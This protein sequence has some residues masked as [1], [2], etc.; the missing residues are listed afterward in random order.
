MRI[1]DSLTDDTLWADARDFP[2]YIA[3][4]AMAILGFVLELVEYAR[5]SPA[6]DQGP[7][8]HREPRLAPVREGGVNGNSKTDDRGVPE[9]KK[10]RK[11]EEKHEEDDLQER[12][13]DYEGEGTDPGRRERHERP[14]QQ[15]RRGE[16]RIDQDEVT[17]ISTEPKAENDGSH[18][19]LQDH[20]QERI[21]PEQP[22]S[23][24][25]S[26]EH[27]KASELPTDSPN[28]YE[29]PLFPRTEQ[30]IMYGV[31]SG[32][33]PLRMREILVGREPFDPYN[34]P[35]CEWLPTWPLTIFDSF[36]TVS[37]E[38][39]EIKMQ[40]Q[41]DMLTGSFLTNALITIV[42]GHLLK[43]YNRHRDRSRKRQE[44][45]MVY[46]EANGGSAEMPKA[47]P[48]LVIEGVNPRRY[49][50]DDMFEVQR[51]GEPTLVKLF[52]SKIAPIEEIVP[53][54]HAT[55]DSAMRKGIK[56]QP[57]PTHKK[58]GKQGS[59]LVGNTCKFSL[60][61]DDEE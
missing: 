43:Y 48:W 58:R 28:Q 40:D 30:A 4:V 15:V 7:E 34:D 56:N 36:P 13:K 5:S 31:T 6:P 45:S 57:L 24:E 25:P 19:K 3:P 38:I 35:P 44:L 54:K 46:R 32:G 51:M 10:V 49:G 18:K 55:K 29:P 9:S 53:G 50:W 61:A 11:H 1:P 14:Q 41:L 2:S 8:G 60:W 52:E 33:A 23:E 39:G 27:S 20:S 26:K 12:A 17:R 22:N 37:F 21:L 16:E 47:N 42:S 59:K